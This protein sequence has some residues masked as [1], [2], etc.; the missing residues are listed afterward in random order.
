MLLS[1]DI[2]VSPW[3]SMISCYYTF[4]LAKNTSNT[5]AN[6]WSPTRHKLISSQWI[7]SARETLRVF[8]GC[9]VP[10]IVPRQ[11]IPYRSTRLFN[12][13][14]SRLPTLSV[15][16]LK[17]PDGV[18]KGWARGGW[19]KQNR[20][21]GNVTLLKPNSWVGHFSALPAFG[22]RRFNLNGIQSGWK[23]THMYIYTWHIIIQ[24]IQNPHLSM[25]LYIVFI[26]KKGINSI[27]HSFMAI[28]G[29][30]WLKNSHL[31]ARW[32]P[33]GMKIHPNVY[34]PNV[35]NIKNNSDP[36]A[37]LLWPNQAIIRQTMV[38]FQHIQPLEEGKLFWMISEDN[39]TSL[40]CV[41][42]YDSQ[43]KKDSDPLDIL[44]W[45]YL[46][47]IA[48]KMVPLQHFELYISAFQAFERWKII[49]NDIRSG[50]NLTQM[51]ISIW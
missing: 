16:L 12:D 8:T 15:F 23:W 42:V 45:P 40:K 27:D 44:L 7:W 31:Y 49:L 39:E 50:W 51:C 10:R 25:Y 37:I 6:T 35:F 46:A 32:Y 20:S 47:I 38:I 9:A 36:W 18:R 3:F 43:Y 34:T 2:H 21:V 13:S 11:H 30:Y 26:I 19:Y 5:V 24:R 33:E 17:L 48:T 41:S 22:R 4:F 14:N 29:H 28:S 1:S